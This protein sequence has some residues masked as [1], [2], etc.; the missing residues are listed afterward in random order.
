[1]GQDSKI[2]AGAVVIHN[3]PPY[4]TVVVFRAVVAQGEGAGQI[5]T[6][7]TCRSIGGHEVMA[8]RVEAG[9][10]GEALRRINGSGQAVEYRGLHLTRF[11]NRQRRTYNWYC[12]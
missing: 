5:W 10:E 8:L 2:G 7:R 4:S 1:M 3:V 6:T 11:R 12:I 9:G